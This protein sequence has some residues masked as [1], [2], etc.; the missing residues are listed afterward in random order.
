METNAK[1]RS[2]ISERLTELALRDTS[3]TKVKENE[4]SSSHNIRANRNEKKADNDD[5]TGDQN[6]FKKVEMSIFNGEDPDS[7]LF[8]VEK[9]FQIHKLTESEKML[10]PT[11]SFDEL[12]LN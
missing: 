5:S 8:C 9:Y 12:A 4:A 11:I 3:T 2:M 7:W 6:K 1:E 10:V